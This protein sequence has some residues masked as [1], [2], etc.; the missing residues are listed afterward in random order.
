MIWF[1]PGRQW[2]TPQSDGDSRIVGAYFSPTTQIWPHACVR[3]PVTGDTNADQ[4]RKPICPSQ[5]Q[6]T[7]FASLIAQEGTRNGFWRSPR[8][9]SQNEFGH[10]PAKI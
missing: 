2:V 7:R 3:A 1:E 10:E 6:P 5:R 9:S 4:L 8:V